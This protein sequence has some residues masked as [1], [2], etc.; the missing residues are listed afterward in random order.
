MAE[1][2]STATR[3]DRNRANGK[4]TRKVNGHLKR[5]ERDNRDKRMADLIGKGKFPYTPTV[6]SWLSQKLGKP[7]ARVTEAEAKALTKKK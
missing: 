4:I 7:A 2:M 3:M 1:R 6:Q 5:R